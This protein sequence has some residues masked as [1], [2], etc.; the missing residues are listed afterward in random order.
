MAFKQKLKSQE[1]LEEGSVSLRC[2]LSKPGIPVAWRKGEKI[3]QGQDKY[4]MK[5]EGKVAEMHISK[6]CL[7][8]AGEYSCV[9]GEV[10]TTADIKVRGTKSHANVWIVDSDLEVLAFF[11]IFFL[12]NL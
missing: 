5:Q 11:W 4:L 6:V 9:A 2:E 1:V 12:N 10:K 8:D 7:Q 3:L